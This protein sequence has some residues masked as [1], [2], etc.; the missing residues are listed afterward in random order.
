M[1]GPIILA[2]IGSGGFTALVARWLDRRK[3]R[4]EAES[5]TVE[6]AHSV[7]GMLRDQVESLSRRVTDVEERLT[8][9]QQKTARLRRWVTLLLD[10]LRQLGVE[11][12]AEPSQPG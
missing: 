12:A 7:V 3:T 2:V 6:T 5:I 1:I 4:A 11:P 9:E 10:Q 8:R